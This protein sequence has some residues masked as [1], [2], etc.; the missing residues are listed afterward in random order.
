[1][2]Q[3]VDEADISEENLGE[4]RQNRLLLSIILCVGLAGLAFMA[5]QSQKTSIASDD[6][7]LAKQERQTYLQAIAT[8]KA[9]MRRARLTDFHIAYPESQR[10]PSVSAQLD[11]LNQFEGNN[12][13]ELTDII[14]DS[15]RDKADKL[16]AL[17][18]YENQWNPLLLGGRDTEIAKIRENLELEPLERPN[19]KMDDVLP[20]TMEVPTET[21]LVG[22]AP[23]PV[24]TYIPPPAPIIAEPIIIE[25]VITPARIRKESKPRYPRRAREAGVEGLVVLKLHIQE[26]GRVDKTEVVYVSADKYKRDFISAAKRSARYTRFH[27]R[28]ID[29]NP[30]PEIREKR[31]KFTLID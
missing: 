18:I 9:A 24:R 22:G 31:Y 29:G 19:R 26:N 20:D 14:F 30:S 21:T 11:V 13:A 23:D 2:Y 5:F 6:V 28:E 12:W 17:A 7:N 27:P 15:D 10:R 3:S 4:K 25:P 1:M 16:A 8:P